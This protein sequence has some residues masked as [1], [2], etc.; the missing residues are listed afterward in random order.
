[1]LLRILRHPLPFLTN[2]VA[3]G[4]H[5]FAAFLAHGPRHL[6]AAGQDWLL[7]GL[8][9]A[10]LHLPARLDLAGLLDLLLQ[11]FDLTQA[12][13]LRRLRQR[14]PT[15]PIE[16]LQ[17][18]LT[19]VGGVALALWQHGPQAAWLA[20]SAHAQGLRAQA[21]DFVQQ[22]V[23]AVAARAVPLFLASLAV[24]GGAFLQ[25]ARGLYNGVMLFV[26]K[27]RQLAQVGQALFASAAAIAAGQLTPAATAVE[28]TLVKL[29]PVALAFLARQLGLDGLSGA[30]QTGLQ[31]VQVPVEKALN[32]VL[33][34]VAQKANAIWGALKAGASK[35]V[36]KGKE[37]ATAVGT[38]VKGWL[39]LRK[40]FTNPEG[41]QH[42]LFLQEGPRLMVASTPQPLERYLKAARTRAQLLPPSPNDTRGKQLRLIDEAQRLL[43]QLPTYTVGKDGPDVAQNVTSLLNQL[44]ELMARIGGVDQ[45]QDLPLPTTTGFFTRS[46]KQRMAAVKHVSSQTA[47]V[48]GSI[49][50]NSPQGWELLQKAGLTTGSYWVKMHMISDKTGGPPQDEN[51]LP[52]PGRLNTGQVLDFET[53]AKELMTTPQPVPPLPD[54][55]PLQH[56]R[57]SVLW[58]TATTNGFHPAGRTP[59]TARLTSPEPYDGQT[60]ATGIA[61]RAG[62]VFYHPGRPASPW[63]RDPVV[64][65]QADVALPLPDWTRTGTPSINLLGREE[66]AAVTGCTEAFARIIKDTQ[67]SPTGANLPF[68]S[69]RDFE[70][71]MQI[72]AHRPSFADNMAKVLAVLS[73]TGK[74][75]G[76]NLSIVNPT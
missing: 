24:P 32:K 41:E 31:K 46:G 59:A 54:L 18:M 12:A 9:Q 3:A 51:L 45:I 50:A 53:R 23:L 44:S 61:L 8:A 71:R 40:P 5:G 74:E 67:K 6:R 1:M 62:L 36:N 48:G 25:L 4:K 28:N 60:F 72:H 42:T 7:G 30:I 26:E 19:Q 37:V 68:D 14:L 22:Q 49:K 39:G 34:T 11:V 13:M 57:Y 10:G 17:A 16:R 55:P 70:D 66:L 63:E 33:D 56:K 35:A 69:V 29:L 75:P 2:L 64:R 58:I 20:I 21:L 76:K 73:L 15:L 47:H 52:A 43:Q 65:L 27:G 38:T